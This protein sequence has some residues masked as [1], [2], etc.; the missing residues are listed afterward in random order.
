[1]FLVIDHL[2]SFVYNLTAYLREAGLAVCVMRSNQI[3]FSKLDRLMENEELEGVILSPGPGKPQ[4]YRDSF[5]LLLKCAGKVPVLG[6][7]LGHQIIGCMFGAEVVRGECPMHGKVSRIHHRKEGIFANLP[8]SFSVT[9][10]HSLVIRQE[11]LPDVLC[12]DAWSE[13]DA[14]MAVHHRDWP[15]YGVQF[16][17]EA[18]LTEYGHELLYN[19]VQIC[20]AR[21]GTGQV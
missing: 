3:D 7:C 18:V 1:M 4:D 20:S 12:V 14:V 11:S 6:V 16:H 10:Y 15:I 5:L 2:D 13:D 19:F 17:P 9:R 21:R 8:E